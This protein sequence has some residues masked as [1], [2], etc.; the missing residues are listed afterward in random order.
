ML[1]LPAL[2]FARGAG[3]GDTGTNAWSPPSNGKNGVMVK[4][5]LKP[6]VFTGVF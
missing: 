1:N 6:L 3:R 4:E 2:L 5:I